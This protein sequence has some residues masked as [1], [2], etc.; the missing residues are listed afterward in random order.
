MFNFGTDKNP[1]YLNLVSC[2]KSIMINNF[3]RATHEGNCED[4][5]EVLLSIKYTERKA[6]S[7]QLL[8]DIPE[9]NR[10][11]VSTIPIPEFD[12]MEEKVLF[13]IAGYTANRIVHVIKCSV[14]KSA[15][16]EKN[17][18]SFQL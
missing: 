11:L 16:T 17:D 9:N 1:Y 10:T 5:D 4:L 8:F 7:I 3:F 15:L 18:T 2:L 12:F 6:T 14:C 13:Y